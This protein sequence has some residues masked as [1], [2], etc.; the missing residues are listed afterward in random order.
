MSI[1]CGDRMSAAQTPLATMTLRAW[2]TPAAVTNPDIRPP[3]VSSEVTGQF[4]NSR[5]PRD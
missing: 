5:P 4:S 3:E 1:P 2:H